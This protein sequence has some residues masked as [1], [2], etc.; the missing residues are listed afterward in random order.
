MAGLAR[1]GWAWQGLAWLGRL[2][3]ARLGKA[4]VAGLGKARTGVARHGRRGKAWQARR[5]MKPE[6]VKEMRENA[7]L[8]I[9][10]AARC[11]QIADRS[12]QRYESGDRQIPPG[13]VELFCIKNGIKYPP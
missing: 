1:R 2:G 6:A 10:Q 11:V 12:W 13:L 8:S 9:A 3:R 5:K 7:G 4:G